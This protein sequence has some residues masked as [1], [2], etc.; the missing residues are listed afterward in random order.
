MGGISITQLLIIAVIVV[1]LFG[2][3]KL[4][5]LGSDLGASIKGFKKAIGDDNTPPTNT[6]EKS[7]LDDADFTAKP[8][9][10]KQPEVKTEESKNKEQV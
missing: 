8:I 5:T 10:D 3:K 2:T 9:T 6:A 1:L 7:S 4:R